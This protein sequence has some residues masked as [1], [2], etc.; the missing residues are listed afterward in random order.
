MMPGSPI[1]NRDF[2]DLGRVAHPLR[3]L[4]RVGFDTLSPIAL[5]AKQQPEPSSPPQSTD[6]VSCSHVPSHLCQ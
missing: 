2:C 6:W 4:Q 1:L 5:A 3:L